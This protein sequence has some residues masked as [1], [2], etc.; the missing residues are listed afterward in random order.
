MH[1]CYQD[2]SAYAIQEV[3]L[4]YGCSESKKDGWVLLNFI[5]PSRLYRSFSNRFQH[6][7]QDFHEIQVNVGYM[8]W[9][10][11]FQWKTKIIRDRICFALLSSVTGSTP[12]SPRAVDFFFSP[13]SI[14]PELNIKVTKI[15]EM[16]TN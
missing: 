2:C 4:T 13:N 5:L 15:I 6:K 3:L 7:R 9:S 14:T 11:F 8:N 16:I 1:F 10:K 12:R